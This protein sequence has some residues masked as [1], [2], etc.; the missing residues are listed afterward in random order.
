MRVISLFI[1]FV[2]SSVAVQAEDYLD[3]DLESLMKVKI[4]GSTLREE[5]VETVPSSVTVFT[6]QQIH[7]LGV[8]YL[9]ELVSLVPGFQTHRSTDNG[10]NYSLSARG[11]RQTTESREL[12][13]I[14]DGRV[15][16]SPIS[17][18]ADTAVVLYSL[19][20]VERVEVIRIRVLLFMDQVP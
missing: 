5:S 7:R 9:H 14:V 11:R 2:L 13:L 4:T 8:D 6:R 20:N 15:L 3:M 17:G 18:G 10:F 12:M 19:A 16:A 1:V